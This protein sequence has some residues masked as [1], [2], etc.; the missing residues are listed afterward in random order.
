VNILVNIELF[1]LKTECD[2]AGRFNTDGA[3]KVV[4]AIFNLFY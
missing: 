4:V 3:I 2:C 1:T